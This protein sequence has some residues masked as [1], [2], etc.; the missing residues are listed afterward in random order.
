MDL[1]KGLFSLSRP[2]RIHRSVKKAWHRFTAAKWAEESASYFYSSAAST[3]AILK[4]SCYISLSTA[5]TINCCLKC[6]ISVQSAAALNVK[7]LWINWVEKQTGLTKVILHLALEMWL[8]PGIMQTEVQG[9]GFWACWFVFNSDLFLFFLFQLLKLIVRI[10]GF[11]NLANHLLPQK[12]QAETN[13]YILNSKW[14]GEEL[15]SRQRYF[16]FWG[17]C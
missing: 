3:L 11:V 2:L 4:H 12:R 17:D 7:H 6:S 10:Q 14:A 5:E 8:I 9:L 15:S 1:K 13:L 16:H